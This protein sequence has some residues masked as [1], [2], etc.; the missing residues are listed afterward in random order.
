M[1]YDRFSPETEITEQHCN[2]SA[3]FT[4]SELALH[5]TL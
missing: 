2:K 5:I 3:V 4:L 1:Q